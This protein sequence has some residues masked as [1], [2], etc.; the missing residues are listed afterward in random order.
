ME[1]KKK[2]KEKAEEERRWREKETETLVRIDKSG[3]QVLSIPW[4]TLYDDDGRAH[5]HTH[6]VVRRKRDI[7]SVPSRKGEKGWEEPTQKDLDIHKTFWIVRLNVG[8]KPNSLKRTRKWRGGKKKEGK[9]KKK[10][11]ILYTTIYPLAFSTA[12]RSLFPETSFI[13]PFLFFSFP[14]W[15]IRNTSTTFTF[16]PRWCSLFFVLFF[17]LYLF[18]CVTHGIPHLLWRPPISQHTFT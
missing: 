12:I 4:A 7:D 6:I 2:K 9:N 5:T 1:R 13:L 14:H 10:K 17:P 11:L 16:P 8:W 18:L 3:R 15:L